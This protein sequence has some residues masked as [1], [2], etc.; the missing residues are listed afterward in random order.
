MVRNQA[1]V[2][3]SVKL[4]YIKCKYIANILTIGEGPRS[5]VVN[6]QD[7]DIK[8]SEFKLYY[9]HLRLNTLG[10][11]PLFLQLLVK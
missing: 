2:T 8:V 7:C 9:V 4:F 5:V 3:D 1:S 6:V 11:N 10:M